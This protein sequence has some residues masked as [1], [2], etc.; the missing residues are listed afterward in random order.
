VSTTITLKLVN[1]YAA[2]INWQVQGIEM[3]WIP[4]ATFYIG[5]GTTTNTAGSG[6]AYSF[7]QGASTYYTVTSENAIAGSAF[8]NP[9]SLSECSGASLVTA[10]AT[11]N[12][13]LSASFPKG[14]A[15]FYCM[16]Y[17]ISQSQYVAFLNDL[18]LVQQGNRTYA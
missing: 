2:S 17:E 4:Q 7:G 16:K 6:S 8:F 11:R 12:S 15:G 14:Y 5:D 18:S 13:A 10:S 9:K 3:V 1:T